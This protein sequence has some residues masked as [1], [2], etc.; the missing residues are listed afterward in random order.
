MKTMIYHLS[1]SAFALLV[2]ALFVNT[3]FP[4]FSYGKLDYVIAF[5]IL[6]GFSYGIDAFL[7]NIK[8]KGITD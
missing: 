7:K 5:T 1:I 3:A 6:L 2:S 8:S 4:D